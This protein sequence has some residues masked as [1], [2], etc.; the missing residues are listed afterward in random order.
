MTTDARNMGA[1]EI[2]TPAQEFKLITPSATAFATVTRAVYV[3]VAGTVDWIDEAGNTS[4]GVTVVAG[5][6]IPVRLTKVTA[7]SSAVLYA[8]R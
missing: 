8:M 7:A 3:A 5:S 2:V 6:V 1:A 4:T